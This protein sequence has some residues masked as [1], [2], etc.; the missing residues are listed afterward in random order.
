MQEKT[1]EEEFRKLWGEHSPSDY[2][3]DPDCSAADVLSFIS[4]H[5]E[6]AKEE[7][8]KEQ[9]HD[10]EILVNTTIDTLREKYKEEGRKEERERLLN[11]KANVHDQEVITQYKEELLGK[12]EEH[13]KKVR[14]EEFTLSEVKKLITS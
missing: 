7:G 3:N 8:R 1:L 4:Y 14:M 12:I 6:K 11:Q 9:S 10:C 2:Y 13:C 5:V